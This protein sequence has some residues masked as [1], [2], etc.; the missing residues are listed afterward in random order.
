M[1]DNDDSK[2]TLK[3]NEIFQRILDECQ[4]LTN[5]LDNDKVDKTLHTVSLLRLRVDQFLS[6]NY[7]A[8]SLSDHLSQATT[9]IPLLSDHLTKIPIGSSASQTAVIVKLPVYM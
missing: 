2:N 8:T 9:C 7:S 1:T 6:T 5:F 4:T 3:Q